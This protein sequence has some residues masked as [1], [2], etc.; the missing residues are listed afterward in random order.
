MLAA[1]RS[2]KQTME[3]VAERLTNVLHQRGAEANAALPAE[4]KSVPTPEADAT[5]RKSIHRAMSLLVS[6]DGN[7]AA[8]YPASTEPE[9]EMSKADAGRVA[10]MEAPCQ[11]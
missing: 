3:N 5:R 10:H 1:R 7:S 8:G 11:P 2:Q 4:V 6:A 9:M